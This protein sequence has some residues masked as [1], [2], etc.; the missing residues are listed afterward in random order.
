MS[1]LIFGQFVVVEWGLEVSM[2]NHFIF[3]YASFRSFKVVERARRGSADARR[4]FGGHPSSLWE[5]PDVNFD[6]CSTSTTSAMGEDDDLGNN[7]DNQAAQTPPTN[8]NNSPPPSLVISHALSGQLGLNNVNREG[9]V[10]FSQVS[11]VYS[12]IFFSL[13]E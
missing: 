7:F 4:S 5:T 10:N 13:T 3:V 8:Q 1:A 12:S 2:L 9:L 11:S 6:A